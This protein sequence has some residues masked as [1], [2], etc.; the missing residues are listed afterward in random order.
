MVVEEIRW[1]QN[2]SCHWQSLLGEDEAVKLMTPAPGFPTYITNWRGMTSAIS[3][4]MD[5][6]FKER[7]ALVILSAYQTNKEV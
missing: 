7:G 2:G 6:G 4:V 5:L 3:M 1:S